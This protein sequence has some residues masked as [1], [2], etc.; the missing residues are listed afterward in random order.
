MRP[1]FLILT[2]LVCFAGPSVE[3]EVRLPKVF[4]NDMMVQR[5]QPVRVWGWADPGEAV[6][7]A[8]AGKKSKTKADGKGEWSVELP[9]MK[10]GENLE[11]TVAGKNTI[12]L[13]NLIVGDIWVCSGQSN[14][15]W[16]LQACD[17]AEDIKAADLPKI[18]RIKFDRVGS[19]V[20]ATDAPAV[21]PWQVCTPQT[22]GG[23][24]GAG[25]YF[26]RDIVAKTGVPIGLLDVNWGGSAIEPWIA[27]EGMELVPEL[28]P[29][30]TSRKAAHQA[31]RDQLPKRLD[32]LEQW[33]AAA[34]ASLKDHA[35]IP[36]MPVV[37]ADPNGIGWCAM[38]NGMVHPLTRLPV[39]GMLWYQG[40]SNGSEGQ[41]YF[42]KMQALV[43]GWRKVWNQPEAPFYF[44]QL[45]SFQN[46]NDNPAGG[47]GWAKV[48]EAQTRSLT[49]P[50]T[51]MAVIIDT[52]PVEVAHDIHPKNKLD[53]GSRLA[54]WAMNRDYGLKDVV[55]SGPLYKSMH[56]EGGKVRLAFDHTGAGLMVGSKEGRKPV[57]EDEA[58]E[59]KRF[60]IAGADK[61]WFWAD[62]VIDGDAVVVS[63]PEVKEPVAVRYAFSMNPHG[64]NLYN[65]DGMPAGPFRTDDW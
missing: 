26:A 54:R 55:P 65:R 42:H 37:P 46:P 53:V 43:G 41:T 44:V 34:R 57:V 45:A 9:A 40:E 11:L 2:L 48:R 29:A 12:A 52:V 13:K 14:M 64:A 16:P 6:S 21:T 60:A 7:V 19:P 18:R 8:L 1:R 30:V 33:I 15:E 3:A 32:A 31:Y 27:P 10:E 56:V 39:K 24:T 4:T 17:G 25:F 36:P 61:K 5:D 35:S 47:D 49:I 58:G 38:Y 23:F 63:S 59:L 28:A 50:N 51:G 22:A 20:G 62:A